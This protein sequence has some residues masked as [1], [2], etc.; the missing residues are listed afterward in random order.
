[1]GLEGFVVSRSSNSLF[2][3]TK[4]SEFYTP[5]IFLDSQPGDDSRSSGA[6]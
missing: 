5:G 4:N 1:M 2:C 6:R 3:S